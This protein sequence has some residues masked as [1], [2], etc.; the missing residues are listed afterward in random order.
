MRPASPLFTARTAAW[1]TAGVIAS[2]GLL[3]WFGYHAIEGWR[4]SS[5]LLVERRSAEAADLLVDALTRDMRGVHDSLL[6]S[7][8]WQQFVS[9]KPFEMSGLVASAFARYPYP[10]SFFAWRAEQQLDRIAFFNRSNRRPS[11][12]TSDPGPSRFPVVVEY[13]PAVAQMIMENISQA[14]ALGRRAAVFELVIADVPYQVVMELTYA[15]AYKEK[16][17][18]F[19]GFTVNLP[20]VQ[21]HYFADLTREVWAI[22]GGAEEG[23]T[24]SV[25]DSNGR[26]LAGT[27]LREG[28]MLTQRRQF[29]PMFFNADV[30]D[31]PADFAENPWI[32]QVSAA[33]DPAVSQAI[34]GG[35]RT[36]MLGAASALVL[37]IGLVLSARAQRKSAQLAELRSDFVSTVT[38]ELKT[39]IATIRAA[40]ETLSQGRISGLDAFQEYARLVVGES[41]RLGRLVENLLAYSRV[42]DIADVYVTE[43]VDVS[44]LVSEILEEFEAQLEDAGFDIHVDI[45]PDIPLVRGDSLALRLLFNNLIDNAIRYSARTRRLTLNAR[46]NG[47]VVTID[48]V[49]AGIGI[50]PDE[51]GQI[52]RK[53]VRGRRAPS[54]GSGLGLAITARI[55]QDHQGKLQIRSELGSGTTVSVSLPAA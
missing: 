7:S 49:D 41:K 45:E 15:D 26:P 11:W 38:H 19:V 53:F 3:F 48:V 55:V 8:Q 50:P 35:N 23:L 34:Q 22:G 43:P 17:S 44:V 20:W 21:Q 32:V 16:L 4:T 28:E 30:V 14:A 27:P 36:I 12:M 24:V 47:R 9:E 10:E 51:I 5:V 40:A 13:E 1:L 18:A 25:I 39:P 33:N 2:V 6:R 46:A 42:T 31:P 54:S 52:T 29:S 37:A